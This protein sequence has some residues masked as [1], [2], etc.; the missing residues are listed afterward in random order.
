M[1]TTL[2]LMLLGALLLLAAGAAV[3]VLIGTGRRPLGPEAPALGLG[4]IL[5]I[6][7]PAFQFFAAWPAA[8][9]VIAAIA[10]LVGAAG[11]VAW[12]HDT[13]RL[14]LTPTRDLGGVLIA[15]AVVSLVLITPV[16]AGGFPTT[17]SWT[18][19]DAWGYAGM[20]DWLQTHPARGA[21]AD[22]AHPLSF[23][24][25]NYDSRA[26]PPGFESIGAVIAFLTGRQGY[27]VVGP[28]YA[29]GGLVAVS[30][31]VALARAL[32][33][34][35]RSWIV[36]VAA[37]VAST[38]P[39]LVAAFV[40][41]Y[42][43]QFLSLCMWP[44]AIALVLRAA[45]TPTWR[46]ALAAGIGI[47]AVAS[48]YPTMLIWTAAAIA[49]AIVATIAVGPRRGVR[50]R[51]RRA[52]VGLVGTVIAT[53]VLAPMQVA[54]AAKNLLYLSG[55]P[56][57]PGFPFGPAATLTET[58]LGTTVL[59]GA[60]PQTPV[61]IVATVFV[62]VLGI[63]ILAMAAISTRTG[64]RGAL[65]VAGAALPTIVIATSY[66][67]VA[68]YPYGAYKAVTL[69]GALVMGCVLMM[70]GGVPQHRRWRFVATISALVLV[71]VTWLPQTR[72]LLEFQAAPGGT[73]FRAPDVQL[74]RQFAR[75][76]TTNTVLV[77]GTANTG[78]A[79]RVRMM[80]AYMAD[81]THGPLIEGIGT[82]GTYLTGGG[83]DDW[84]PR[85][86][87]NEVLAYSP[88]PFVTQRTQIWS[89]P[90]YSL[91]HA[92]VVDVTPWGENWSVAESA[93]GI[94]FAWITG[95]AAIL[96]SNRGGRR[97]DVQLITGLLSAGV[98]RR[99]TMQESGARPVNFRA[100]IAAVS[101]ASLPLTLAAHSVTVVKISTDPAESVPQ[102]PD[103]RPLVLRIIGLR[104]VPIS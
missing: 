18:N 75:I 6:A 46:R 43:N 37:M 101:R 98:G 27:Q 38:S 93:N 57:N 26:F 70:V 9:I 41:V 84:R 31:W 47:G 90:P 85:Q 13:P 97:V 55:K 45:R 66:S 83:L 36:A 42:G 2:G 32:G 51:G 28:L 87:W 21:I 7:Y 67:G 50:I 82:T 59:P 79:F 24:A 94:P 104:V 71:A 4:T 12:R 19:W 100:S 30:S 16:L 48:V 102:A 29:L 74:G 86:P 1:L 92:P 81:A 25:W 3:S 96:V 61:L 76:P 60:I 22:S 34:R 88:S 11:V 58:G 56:G 15:G 33:S 54:G 99:V 95:P 14:V 63:A 49:L 69:G 35:V 39:M 44:L 64:R 52:T 68:G 8:I 77:E 20:V 89:D 17:I 5:L 62:I 10:V 91:F 23:I 72:S 73:G 80:S 40:Q 53:V 65:I 103:P 78:D